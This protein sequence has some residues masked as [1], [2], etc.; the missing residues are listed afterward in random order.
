VQIGAIA[1]A[2]TA[3]APW[4]AVAGLLGWALVANMT[5]PAA[6]AIQLVTPN[7]YRGQVSAAYILVFNLL[8]VGAGATTAGAFT[9]YLFRDDLK[10]GWSILL[11][12]AIFMP[13]SIACLV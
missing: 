7:E 8:G 4:A 13:I 12:F 1:V 11:T 3:S 9:T 6:A 10:V 5:G 2:M